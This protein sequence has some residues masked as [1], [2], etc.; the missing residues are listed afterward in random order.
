ML[1]HLPNGYTPERVRDALAAKIQTLPEVLRG[2]LTWDQGLE[3][4]DW[5]QIS[6]AAES[7]VATTERTKDPY[8]DTHRPSSQQALSR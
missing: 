6:V 1:V 7:R 8:S 3:M 4:R 2:S 5:K